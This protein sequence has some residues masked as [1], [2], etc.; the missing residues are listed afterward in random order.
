MRLRIVT[1]VVSLLSALTFAAYSQDAPAASN[2]P[3]VKASDFDP[4]LSAGKQRTYDHTA[5]SVATAVREAMKSGQF[6][7]L[8]EEKVQA[9]TVFEAV[10]RSWRNVPSR[11]KVRIVVDPVSEQQTAVRVFWRAASTFTPG[12]PGDPTAEGLYFQA[13][14]SRLR[15]YGVRTAAKTGEK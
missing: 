11:D 8:S 3:A 5:S 4:P 14:E 15:G 12:S 10:I 6:K 13:I 9:V 7:L 2:V 1:A